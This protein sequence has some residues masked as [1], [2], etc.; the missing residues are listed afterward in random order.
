METQT[1]SATSSPISP[2]FRRQAEKIG[3]V[4]AKV[5]ALTGMLGYKA[6]ETHQ[7]RTQRNLEAEDKAVRTKLW[8]NDGGPAEADQMGGNTILGDVT[9]P[10]P[11]IVTGQQSSGLAKT[12]AGIAIGALIPG[13]GVGGY[14]L[15]QL[16]N[17][18][19]SPVIEQGEHMDLGLGRIQDY[20]EQ[21]EGP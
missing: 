19:A 9:H 21:E 7:A 11:V 6:L 2:D 4:R 20:L 3:I 1:E 16:G 18:T 5:E 12:L 8:G 10:T 15:S 13:A 14:L 17:K